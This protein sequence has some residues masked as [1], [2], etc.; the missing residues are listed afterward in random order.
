M[1]AYDGQRPNREGKANKHRIPVEEEK[2][3]RERGYYL[4]PQVFDQPEEKSLEWA[5]NPEMLKQIKSR[6]QDAELRR[7]EKANDR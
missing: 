6:R 2:P 7:R 1:A 3:D 4:H 5:R